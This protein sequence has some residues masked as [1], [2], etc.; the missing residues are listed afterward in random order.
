MAFSFVSRCLGICVLGAIAA[1]CSAALP[2]EPSFPPQAA[3][4]VIQY[5][6]GGTR[7]V[8]GTG[9]LFAFAVDADGIYTNVTN[10]AAWSTSDPQALRV[11]GSS[12]SGPAGSYEVYAAFQGMRGVL[13]IEIRSAPG[14]PNIEI[15]LTGSPRNVQLRPAATGSSQSVSTQVTWTSS[16]ERLA[17]VDARG[18]LT[19]LMPGNVR[20]TA[21]FN[22]MSDYYWVAV[23]PRSRP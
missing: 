21:T 19:P 18:Y 10:E 22:N 13:P 20:I 8:G 15:S 14:F 16:D 1:S 9:Q 2:T 5:Q 23:P 12:V 3:T 11:Q 7:M 4:I 6:Q 17:T